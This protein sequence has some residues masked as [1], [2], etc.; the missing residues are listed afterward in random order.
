MPFGAIASIAGA[1]IGASSAKSTNKAA[2]QEAENSRLFTKEQLQNRHQWEV[3]DLRKAGLNPVL[4]AHSGAAVGG[5]AQAPVINPADGMAKAVEAAASALTLKRTEAEIDKIKSETQV[6]KS[7][8][9]LKKAEYPGVKG[10]SEATAAAA[11]TEK[12][13]DESKWGEFLRYLNRINPFANSAK[14]LTK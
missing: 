6:N 1:L 11:K 9:K 3:E 8:D 14:G 4:S 5:S 13:I 7:I 2:A 10:Q 12:Q